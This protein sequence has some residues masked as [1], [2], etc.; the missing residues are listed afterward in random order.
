MLLPCKQ[1]AFKPAWLLARCFRVGA[2]HA[3]SSMGR[4]AAIV[5]VCGRGQAGSPPVGCALQNDMICRTSV[6][7]LRVLASEMMAAGEGA[8]E[9]SQ[10]RSI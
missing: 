10:V 4:P 6:T 3:A 5:V 2:A 7:S 9:S 1:G 8:M